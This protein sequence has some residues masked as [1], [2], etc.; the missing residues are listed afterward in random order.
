MNFTNIELLN[1]WNDNT[2]ILQMKDNYTYIQF[3]NENSAK[4]KLKVDIT[5]DTT[6]YLIDKLNLIPKVNSWFND[7]VIWKKEN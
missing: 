4:P 3:T 7:T 2:Q 6:E 1:R 5:K